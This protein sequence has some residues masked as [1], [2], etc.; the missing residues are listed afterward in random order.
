MDH[1]CDEI[2]VHCG[3][4][5]VRRDGNSVMVHNPVTYPLDQILM[6]FFLARNQGVIVHAAGV[7]MEGKGLIFAGC[8][9]AGKSTLSRLLMNEPGMRVLSDD[10]IIVRKKR[11]GFKMHGTPWHGDAGLAENRSVDLKGVFFLK[12]GVMNE[13]C[14]LSHTVAFERLLTVAS[15][16]WFER[17]VTDHILSVCENVAKEIPAYEFAFVPDA[18]AAEFVQRMGGGAFSAGRET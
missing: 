17:V 10:R 5:L 15:V 9:G 13:V 8:S 7:E 11:D 18:G 4:R 1:E 14:Q 6:M 2:T 3:Q 12:H 16:P